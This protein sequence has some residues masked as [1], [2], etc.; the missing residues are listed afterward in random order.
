MDP[1]SILYE[2]S[3][4][5]LLGAAAVLVGAFGARSHPTRFRARRAMTATAAECVCYR[6]FTA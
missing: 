3:A 5:L 4:A 6:A 1:V 2:A